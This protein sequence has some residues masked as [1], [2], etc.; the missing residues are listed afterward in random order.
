MWRSTMPR[1]VLY[2][3]NNVEVTAPHTHPAA[4]LFVYTGGEPNIV[5]GTLDGN[6]PHVAT[7][8][9]ETNL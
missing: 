1:Y 5:G 9:T 4:G 8:H 6:R 7:E 2:P 3:T